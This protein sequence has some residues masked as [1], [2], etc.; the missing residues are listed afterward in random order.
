MPGYLCLENVIHMLKFFRALGEKPTG[1]KLVFIS[2]SF[3]PLC[4]VG[5]N[6]CEI[7]FLTP[8]LNVVLSTVLK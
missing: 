6:F 2:F 7:I 3:T 8:I 4:N 5:T 1:L